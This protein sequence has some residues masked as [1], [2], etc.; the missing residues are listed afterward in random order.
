MTEPAVRTAGGSPVLS[1]VV[2]IVDGG[3]V[4]RRFLDALTHQEDAPTMEIIVPFDASVAETA[5]FQDEFPTILFLDLG[6]IPTERPIRSAAGQHELYDRRRAAGLAATRGEL[7]AILEDRGAPR[8]D[9]AKSV[10]RL[11][12]QPYAVIGGAIEPARGDLLN[13]AFYVCDFGRYGLPFTSGPASWV[14]DVNVTYKRKAVDE[15][16]H[17]WKER[18]REPVVHWALQERGETL[19]LSSDLVVE[20]RRPPTTLAVL[21]PERFHWGRLFGHIRAMRLSTPKRL[22]Y[23]LMGPLIPLV[24]FVRHARTQQKKGHFG[25]YMRAA[26]ATALLLIAWTTGEVWGYLT[27]RA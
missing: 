18:F 10:V 6:V 24:L 4:L 26:P 20:H 12:Q 15:T 8:S 16:R 11:H 2:T 5:S 14:S 7:V 1:I 25:R 23:A 19:Y 3:E 21:L 13:W 9:W 27:K 22:A 17:L